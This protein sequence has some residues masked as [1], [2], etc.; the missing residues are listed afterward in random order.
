MVR[1]TFEFIEVLELF[2]CSMSISAFKEKLRLR[3][4]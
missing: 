3:Y 4:I 1:M 2:D